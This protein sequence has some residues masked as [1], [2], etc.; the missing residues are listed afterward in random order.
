M[1]EEIE[2]VVYFDGICGL[3]DWFVNLL[4]KIDTN[5]NLKFSS[6]QGKSGQTL[7]S[8][9]KMDLNEFNTVL[10]KVNDQVYTKS[11]AVFKIIKSI[12]GF[13]KIFLIFNLLPTRFN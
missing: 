6:L 9:L 11:T 8:A 13:Y 10:F 7:L 1:K 2:K 3:C 4:V 5:N 12:G